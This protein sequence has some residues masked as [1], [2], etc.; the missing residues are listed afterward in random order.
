MKQT[1]KSHDGHWQRNIERR[2]TTS[3]IQSSPA[4]QSSDVC[5]IMSTLASSGHL[6]VY[7]TCSL[8]SVRLM[9]SMCGIRE[10]V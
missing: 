5:H 4:R 8:V 7:Y 1:P 9:N 6:C 2:E 10:R 3:A